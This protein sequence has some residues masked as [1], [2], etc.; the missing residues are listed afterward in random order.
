MQTAVALAGGVMITIAS[1]WIPALAYSTPTTYSATRAEIKTPIPAFL[2][3]E[4]QAPTSGSIGSFAPGIRLSQLTASHREDPELRLEVTRQRYGWPIA[5][6]QTV[7][8]GIGGA[9]DNAWDLL[10]ELQREAGWLDGLPIANRRL[11]LTPIWPTFLA[12]VACSGALLWTTL[13]GW[14]HARALAWRR[15]GRCGT[16]GYRIEGDGPCPECG[17][18]A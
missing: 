6:A 13:F 7:H 15:A 1:A 11:P 9:G 5:V 2:R 17:S 4:W 18:V 10:N 16:C 12:M 3:D 14:R 8:F